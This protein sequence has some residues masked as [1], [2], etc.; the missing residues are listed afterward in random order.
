MNDL[1]QYYNTYHCTI[2]NCMLCVPNFLHFIDILKRNKKLYL[3]CCIVYNHILKYFKPL[4][5]SF[6]LSWNDNLEFGCTISLNLWNKFRLFSV[7]LDYYVN[8]LHSK[9]C[10]SFLLCNILE[11]KWHKDGYSSQ[12]AYLN[13]AVVSFFLF[14][15]LS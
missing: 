10:V 3:I 11:T 7:K 13:P 14:L 1:I 12:D 5:F 15:S 6:K 8:F 4:T 9:H 2:R